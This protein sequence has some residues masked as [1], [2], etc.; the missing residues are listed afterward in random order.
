[1]RIRLTGPVGEVQRESF[2][3][4]PPVVTDS[5]VALDD[6]AFD[7]QSLQSRGEHQAAIR[8]RSFISMPIG[9]QDSHERNSL[10]SSS[11]DQDLGLDVLQL[12]IDL[13][14]LVPCVRS[15][16]VSVPLRDLGEPMQ[17]FHRRGHRPDLVALFGLDDIDQSG[18][19]GEFGLQADVS[20]D[21]RHVPVGA[22]DFCIRL[23]EGD[24]VDGRGGQQVGSGLVDGLTEVEGSVFPSEKRAV[25]PNTC[26]PN[27]VRRASR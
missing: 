26:D 16:H 21:E 20:L 15:G 11:D 3:S 19:S 8:S 5:L 6:Q 22:F 4:T 13:P 9:C 23:D 7:A 24:L 10:L 12:Q 25:P 14:L 17:R 18:T 27:H 1:M 2:V